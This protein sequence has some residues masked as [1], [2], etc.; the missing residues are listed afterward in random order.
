LFVQWT[1]GVPRVDA[2]FSHYFKVGTSGGIDA[3]CT[4]S[5]YPIA[6]S[7]FV[8]MTNAENRRMLA[9]WGFPDYRGVTNAVQ[10]NLNLGLGFTS[11]AWRPM[12]PYQGR[13]TALYS[14]VRVG[15]GHQGAIPLVDFVKS[16]A[17]GLAGKSGIELRVLL[18]PLRSPAIR[19]AANE[20]D[21]T[22]Y[23]GATGL[24][25]P[26]EQALKAIKEWPMDP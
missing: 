1:N 14:T 26:I 25:V 12:P 9:R 10:W 6:E 19:M 4:L 18:E 3:D 24:A 11:G 2:D 7:H 15:S 5:C 13:E 21:R 23:I 17:D 22:N 8:G 20:I 16:K